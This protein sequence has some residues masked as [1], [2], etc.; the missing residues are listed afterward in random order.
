M[1]IIVA[2]LLPMI[3]LFVFSNRHY[4]QALQD[5][6]V[7]GHMQSLHAFRDTLDSLLTNVVAIRDDLMVDAND[8]LHDSYTPAEYANAI[9]LQERLNRYSVLCPRITELLLHTSGDKYLFS[10]TSS[11]TR[12][13]IQKRYSLSQETISTIMDNGFKIP[14]ILLSHDNYYMRDCFLFMF[15]FEAHDVERT[16]IM[17]VYVSELEN[18]SRLSD[19]PKDNSLLL[20]G[21]DGTHLISIFE[22]PDYADISPDQIAGEML[23]NTGKDYSRT[24]VQGRD[25]YISSCQS[26][27][28]GLQLVQ[29]SS[30]ETII[31]TAVNQ[32]N[33][34]S[35]LFGIVLM[36]TM[37][38]VLPISRIIHSPITK[39]MDHVHDG[40]STTTVHRT[41]QPLYSEADYIIAYMEGIRKQN[42]DLS[43]RLRK[44]H[45]DWDQT[46]F[47]RLLLGEI[48]SWDDFAAVWN[49]NA[50][51]PQT[52][53]YC[54][55]S[56]LPHEKLLSSA[57]IAMIGSELTR[58][59]KYHCITMYQPEGNYILGLL[60]SRRSG[61]NDAGEVIQAKLQSIQAQL[62]Q[63]F[64]IGV[65]G[66]YTD[67]SFSQQSMVEAVCACESVESDDAQATVCQFSLDSNDRYYEDLLSLF[68]TRS[69]F[70]GIDTGDL[71]LWLDRVS[72][73]LSQKGCDIAH[74]KYL[75]FKMLFY[76]NEYVSRCTNEDSANLYPYVIRLI[77]YSDAGEIDQYL[78]S[79]SSVLLRKI[80]LSLSE[81]RSVLNCE[82]LLYIEQHT[83]DADFSLTAMAD[84]FSMS[85][86][87]L[88]KYF[89]DKNG[90]SIMSF[91]TSKRI[92]TACDLLANSDLS[93]KDIGI[94][95]GYVNDSSFI[96]RFK[97]V[98]GISPGQYRS[99][100]DQY[101]IPPANMDFND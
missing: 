40:G 98:M 85:L 72:G 63:T 44:L 92:E 101:R 53:S 20:F 12:S 62:K 35:L 94:A 8:E 82:M 42:R 59:D 23:Q 29:I 6:L 90:M 24:E 19:L 91:M 66:A 25:C 38:L 97:S 64:T 56:V 1:M 51:D 10:T 50:P 69:D 87:I 77:S 16:L 88:G 7:E 33:T 41:I 61:D 83:S 3:L 99:A 15:S 73:Y 43:N 76:L 65:G 60:I 22:T 4:N 47:S 84:H 32:R 37:L 95:V 68:S 46:L 27:I 57:D 74:A 96:R 49:G 39:L 18:M 89:K 79:C 58:E 100:P 86:P 14:R 71:L 5:A 26:N 30:T 75:G 93:V 55:F 48:H 21:Q 28:L 54:I 11:F 70:Q 80:D 17:E 67:T 13:T 31:T 2:L 36:F 78:R 81:Q 9:K 45:N 52:I 34:S